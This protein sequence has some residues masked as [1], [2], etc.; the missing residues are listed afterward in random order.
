MY[1]ISLFI[2]HVYA[3]TAGFHLGWRW[4]LLS[5]IAIGVGMIGSLIA[6]FV[7]ISTLASQTFTSWLGAASLL[8]NRTFLT[9]AF[10]VCIA[11]PLA[12][13]DDLHSLRFSSVLSIAS[14]VAVFAVIVWRS[15][16]CIAGH[17]NLYCAASSSGAPHLPPFEWVQHS[18][19]VMR[20][21]PLCVFSFGCHCQAVSAFFELDE[22]LRSRAA[23][24]RIAGA[25]AT[26]C[27][28]IYIGC[29]TFGYRLFGTAVQG[30]VLLALS[31]D[32]V[33]ALVAKISMAFHIVLA[34]PVLI[35]PTRTMLRR[36]GALIGAK[37]TRWCCAP[38]TP[39]LDDEE[40]EGPLRDADQSSPV[41][42]S[43]VSP[44][45]SSVS[46]VSGSAAAIVSHSQPLLHSAAQDYENATDLSD[47]PVSRVTCCAG[48]CSCALAN[49][50]QAAVVVL[51]SA[52]I[53]VVAPQ[54]Q[55]VFGLMGA[56]SGV[57]QVTL[58]PAVLLLHRPP[59]DGSSGGLQR[60]AAWALIALSVFASVLG[61]ALALIDMM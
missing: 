23:F 59:E 14:V 33:L 46:S 17:E 36:F 56:T 24:A 21:L 37:M 48:R 13:L 35:Y 5:E 41:G 11:L 4:K 6:F 42:A 20:A 39:L 2:F 8:A 52:S 61:T 44:L 30:N 54:V 47:A 29:G 26:T 58:I 16:Q 45:S 28:V 22:H 55:V 34:S 27:A 9:Y 50:A 25:V 31:D 38:A 19:T 18:W 53:A 51:A 40:D 49:F 60:A 32:D 57:V 43:S 10:A 3:S 12:S 15:A 1:I 7:V